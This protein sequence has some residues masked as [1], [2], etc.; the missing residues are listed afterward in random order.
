MA[1]EDNDNC[2]QKLKG[3]GEINLSK[4]AI[5][6]GQSELDNSVE[7]NYGQNSICLFNKRISPTFTFHPQ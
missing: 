1:A 2:G 7:Q 4:L 3:W 5:D 6:F